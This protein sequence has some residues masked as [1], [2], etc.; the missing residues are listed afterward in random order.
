MLRWDAQICSGPTWARITTVSIASNR[1]VVA[2]LRRHEG[3]VRRWDEPVVHTL[4]LMRTHMV[5]VVDPA[6]DYPYNA[7]NNDSSS[8]W[9]WQRSLYLLTMSC[10]VIYRCGV[11]Y[12]NCISYN[13]VWFIYLCPCFCR[14]WCGNETLNQSRIRTAFGK[15]NCS[16]FN[17]VN[18][19]YAC[20]LLI[21]FMPRCCY[22][23]LRAFRFLDCTIWIWQDICTEYSGNCTLNDEFYLILQLIPDWAVQSISK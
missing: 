11:L 5:A 17:D 8:C 6:V 18:P 9:R 13:I 7:G 14:L 3:K 22:I 21:A 4:R 10:G 12:P 20:F 15:Y 2:E 19:D 16:Y 23:T 1:I